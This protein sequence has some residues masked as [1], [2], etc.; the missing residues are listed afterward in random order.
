MRDRSLHATS[1]LPL[2]TPFA[3]AMTTLII[4]NGAYNIK[5][6]LSTK[7]KAQPRW[8]PSIYS[9]VRR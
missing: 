8:L 5:T 9:S 1:T 3:M 6:G 2:P 7:P 4:D